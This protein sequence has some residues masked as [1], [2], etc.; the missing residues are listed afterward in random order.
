M[1][2]SVKEKKNYAKNLLAFTILKIALR[3]FK[4][5]LIVVAITTHLI[6]IAHDIFRKSK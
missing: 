2:K 3:K 1:L 6:K 5:T 4:N